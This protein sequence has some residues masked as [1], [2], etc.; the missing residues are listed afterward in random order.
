MFSH[1]P[2]VKDEHDM[3]NYPYRPTSL[4][5]IK[6]RE[7]QLRE[8]VMDQFKEMIDGPNDDIYVDASD[9]ERRLLIIGLASRV[10]ISILRSSLSR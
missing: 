6:Q 9:T 5:Q 10:E 7:R 4:T 3:P 2:S 1:E 8:S